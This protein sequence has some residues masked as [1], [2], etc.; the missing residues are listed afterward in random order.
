LPRRGYGVTGS[1]EAPPSPVG[2]PEVNLP[3]MDWSD[4]VTPSPAAPASPVPPPASPPRR[5][6]G[7][8]GSWDAPAAPRRAGHGVTGTW[9]A[10]VAPPPPRVPLGGS[11]ISPEMGREAP[12]T[13][14]TTSRPSGLATLWAG[15]SAALRGRGTSPMAD[16]VTPPHVP[17]LPNIPESANPA[18]VKSFVKQA[19]NSLFPGIPITQIMRDE[20]MV[21]ALQR[22]AKELYWSRP[23]SP[24]PKWTYHGPVQA[25]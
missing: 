4:V 13:S 17:E 9:E 16:L 22:R 24:P 21:A 15:I 14:P 1:W 6:Y 5:G 8:S 12:T 20:V 11:A 19:M 18:A 23:P 10:P 7:V 3:K 2:P 25:P